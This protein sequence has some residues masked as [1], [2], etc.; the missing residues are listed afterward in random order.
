MKHRPSLA[1]KHNRPQC[2]CYSTTVIV[3]LP[4]TDMHHCRLL[5]T[6]YGDD[7]FQWMSESKLKV[8][9]DGTNLLTK[10]GELT[11]KALYEALQAALRDSN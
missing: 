5:T 6:F 10:L 8:L 11:N 3:Q 9:D 4:L 7:S 2:C 1:C